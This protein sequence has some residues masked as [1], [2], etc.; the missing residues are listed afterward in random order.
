MKRHIIIISIAALALFG[1]KGNSSKSTADKVTEDVLELKD[2]T[3]NEEKIAEE[4][5][6]KTK[7]IEEA[8]ENLESLL[9]DIE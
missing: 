6:E 5:E 9:E 2:E 8:A 1:C 7:K 4:L 3:I